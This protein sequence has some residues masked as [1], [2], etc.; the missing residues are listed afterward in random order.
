MPRGLNANIT[1]IVQQ[2]L[3]RREAYEASSGIV[4]A[5]DGDRVDLRISGSANVI[6]NVAV[7]GSASSLAVG[8]EVSLRWEN[9]R[10]IALATSTSQAQTIVSTAGAS[11]DV[12]VD[13]DTIEHSAFG[14]RI[15]AGSLQ[16]WHL[17]FTPSVEGHTHKDSLERAGW[18][19]DTD[20]AIF[21][22]D[23]FIHADGQ[24]SLGEGADV[25]KL[26]ST[27]PVYRIW[28]GALTPEAS[29]FS[30]SKTGELYAT[31][32]QIAG[33]DIEADKLT[34]NN[35]DLDPSG[36]I[37]VGTGD[38]I[39]VLSSIDLDDYAF[40]VGSATPATAPFRVKST[41]EVWLENAHVATELES[42]NYASGIAGWKIDQ[43]G[44]AEFNDVTIR[45]EI[46]ASVFKTEEVSVIA[47]RQRITDGTT[48]AIDADSVDT[49]ITLTDPV[50]E[51]HDLLYVVPSAGTKEWMQVTGE[52]TH[53]ADGYEYPVMRA[54]DGMT[55]HDIMAGTSIHSTGAATW[56]D[57]VPLFGEIQF[58]EE[59]FGG[60]PYAA[61]GGFLTLEGSR[62][63]GPYFGVARRF[64][65]HPYQ[66]AD[67]ARFGLVRGFLGI[68]ETEY[69]VA[70]GDAN[71]HFIY[72]YNSGLEI[73]TDEGNLIINDNGLRVDR[74]TFTP[75]TVAPNYV[76]Q[77]LIIWL[78]DSGNLMGRYK[79]GATETEATIQAFG[80]A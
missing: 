70:I 65:P 38:D 72:T 75:R 49:M 55:A 78:D 46:V 39:A 52:Y 35:I 50:F 30:V 1:A 37:T 44:W 32:G 79:D 7:I 43:S 76:D 51:M 13:D 54:A 11:S 60:G 41:G 25:I 61:L 42:T 10:P 6:R 28:A 24:L 22:N 21:K 9:G 14:L 34:K 29:T 40:W 23:T 5:I 69:G 2:V 59:L 66:I 80:G 56:P 26:D 3:A 71:R 57:P 47:G 31:A 48:F 45:G 16:Q 64:G 63:Y 15:K 77:T 62:D 67:V 73:Q 12:E 36:Q 4:F 8:Q 68:G 53:T 74:V 19:V 27:H 20:G 58:G 33:W 17:A 18:Q